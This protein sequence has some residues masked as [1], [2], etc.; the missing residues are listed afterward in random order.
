MSAQPRLLIRI[1]AR[2]YSQRPL[3]PPRALFWVSLQESGRSLTFPYNCF[4]V[5]ELHFIDRVRHGQLIFEPPRK[6][7]P[8]QSEMNINDQRRPFSLCCDFFHRHGAM[9]SQS[10]YFQYKRRS[11]R[12]G[13]CL[14]RLDVLIFKDRIAIRG[15]NRGQITVFANIRD[16]L[17]DI[18]ISLR[19][20]GAFQSGPA[21]ATGTGLPGSHPFNLVLEVLPPQNQFLVER[22]ADSMQ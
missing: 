10:R 8:G 17:E 20:L 4:F 13:C 5:S 14:E 11:I 21:A 12:N 9:K 7:R 6:S 15:Q 19:L 1:H 3:P 22:F 16:S 2:Q 18:V